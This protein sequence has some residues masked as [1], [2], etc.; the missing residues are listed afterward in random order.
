LQAV[1]EGATFESAYEGRARESLADLET[2]ER[3][4]SGPAIVVDRDATGDAHWTLL[5][6]ADHETE[7]A[8]SGASTYV[9]TFTVRTD[10]WGLYRGSFGSTAPRGV[11]VISAAGAQTKFDTRP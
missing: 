4:A 5:A 11:Y 7:V 3:G 9:V 6:A 2:R 1:R 10:Q 8:I